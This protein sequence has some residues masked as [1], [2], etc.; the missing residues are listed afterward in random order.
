MSEERV[1]LEFLAEQQ[2][3]ILADQL[4]LIDEVHVLGASV[5]RIDNT[6]GLLLEELR[7]IHSLLAR[8]VDRVR[9]IEER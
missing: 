7:A 3:R 6:Q 2:R 1:T 9:V 4:T 8:I 5:R